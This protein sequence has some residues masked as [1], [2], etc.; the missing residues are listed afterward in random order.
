VDKHISMRTI[1]YLLLILLNSF[2]LGIY[3]TLNI[4]GI[5][6]IQTYKIC[7]CVFFIAY[8]SIVLIIHLK[9]PNDDDK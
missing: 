6:N 8:F 7:L 3:T 1:L 4:H 2:I 5:K 9:N